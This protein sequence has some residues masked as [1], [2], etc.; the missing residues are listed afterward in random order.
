MSR[1][2]APSIPLRLNAE[3]LKPGEAWLGFGPAPVP[4]P[5]PSPEAGPPPATRNLSQTGDA[6][7]AARNLF[8]YLRELE[9]SG[10]QGIAVAP[11][12]HPSPE[13]DDGPLE[14]LRE[15][16]HRAAEGSGSGEGA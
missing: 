15:R 16:L 3:A 2:Y 4:L 9:A 13:S 5:A 11:L 6:A 7:E 10:A 1:H 12:P 14:A 8:A